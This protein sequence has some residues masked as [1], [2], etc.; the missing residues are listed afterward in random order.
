MKFIKSTGNCALAIF[1]SHREAQAYLD[2]LVADLNAED[3]KCGD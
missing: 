2:K 3:K 1:N